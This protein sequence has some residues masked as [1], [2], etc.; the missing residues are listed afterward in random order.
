MSPTEKYIA[1][2]TM[3]QKYR[4]ATPIGL[5][6]NLFTSIGGMALVAYFANY[7]IEAQDKK[8]EILFEEVKNLKDNE[9]KDILCLTKSVYQCCGEKA[10]AN[11]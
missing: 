2:E 9:S 4:W 5:A 3:M 6:A 8:D 10:N 11:C 7:Y 1:K